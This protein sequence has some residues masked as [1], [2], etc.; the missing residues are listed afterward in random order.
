MG[1]LKPSLLRMA[2][3]IPALVTT[4][5]IAG[6]AS[7]AGNGVLTLKQVHMDMSWKMTAY[8]Q[9]VIAGSVT[10]GQARQVNAAYHE[11]LEA[12]QHALDAAGGNLDAPAPP[13]LKAKAD[14]LIDAI[15]VVLATLT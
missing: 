4:L 14:Q 8:R 5:T 1:N 11:Y 13:D 6:C 3:L 10:E 12:Y 15:S 9:A 7:L 2:V